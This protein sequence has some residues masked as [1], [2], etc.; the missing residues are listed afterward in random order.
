MPSCHTGDPPQQH[1]TLSLDSDFCTWMSGGRQHPTCQALSS[2]PPMVFAQLEALSSMLFT[3][4]H[5][6]HLVSPGD[7]IDSCN[8]NPDRQ[9]LFWS[10]FSSCDSNLE[11][12]PCRNTVL[13]VIKP[14]SGSVYVSNGLCRHWYLTSG[15]V[16]VILWAQ[17][18]LSF[19]AEGLIGTRRVWAHQDFNWLH[20][21]TRLLRTWL[22][23]LHGYCIFLAGCTA[24]PQTG[25]EGTNCT[26]QSGKQSA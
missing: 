17:E 20:L 22:W 26:K 13:S 9:L 3:V 24:E 6:H 23:F 1:K 5:S 11:T 15:W 16:C 4:Q 7:G 14:V 12:L 2:S 18:L 25:V 19:T 10:Y 21:S 8:L